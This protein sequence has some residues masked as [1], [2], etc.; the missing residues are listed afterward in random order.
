[1]L[2]FRV[3]SSSRLNVSLRDSSIN[4]AAPEYDVVSDVVYGWDTKERDVL[5]VG[6]ED[7][8]GGGDWDE[9][10]VCGG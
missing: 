10:A 7:E 9:G 2:L 8:A 5:N 6:I 3:S 1:M 4:E